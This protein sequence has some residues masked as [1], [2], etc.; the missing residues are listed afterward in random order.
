MLN[1]S[2]TCDDSEQTTPEDIKCTTDVWR[3]HEADRGAWNRAGRVEAGVN[4][5]TTPKGN[6]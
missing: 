1:S 4:L 5:C 2:S 6:Y 3:R